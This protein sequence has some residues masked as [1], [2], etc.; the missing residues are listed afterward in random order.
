ML[1]DNVPL[2]VGTSVLPFSLFSTL[3]DWLGSTL[4]SKW[5]ISTATVLV[6]LQ[7][8]GLENS[9]TTDRVSDVQDEN[10]SQQLHNNNLNAE[11]GNSKVYFNILFVVF[12]IIIMWLYIWLLLILLIPLAFWVSKKLLLH[13][14]TTTLIEDLCQ[15][16]FAKTLADVRT[17]VSNYIQAHKDAVFPEPLPRIASV[18]RKGDK[19]IQVNLLSSLPT[20]TTILI[21]L[22]IFSSAIFMTVFL[23]VKIQQESFL[24][25]HITSN[26]INETFSQN[27]EY[28]K[29]LPG[30]ETM[31]K[32][33]DTFVD[34]VYLQGRDWIS[35]KI[36][37]TIGQTAN[38]TKVE[39]QVLQIW[40]QLYHGLFMKKGHSTPKLSRKNSFRSVSDSG[41]ISGVIDLFNMSEVITWLQDNVSA[42]MSL[43]ETLLSVIQSNMTLIMS[44]FT[45]V[46]TTLL[47][48][49]TMVLNFILSLVIFFT[50]LFYLLASSSEQY[51]P[52]EII[53]SVIRPLSM[54][55]PIEKAL[56]EVVSG[57]FGASLKMFGFYGLYTWVN[58]SMFGSNLV[59]IP[60]VLA[61][62]FG[63]VPLITT[64]W[65]CLPSA[66]E[67]WL[68]QGS[69]M[70]AAGLV[71]CQFL[72]TF[73]V[74]TAIYKDIAQ[75][76]GGTHP[77][78]TGLA[79]AGGVYTF[80]LEGAIAGPLI[81]CLVLVA[82]N[83][84][85]TATLTSSNIRQLF[86]K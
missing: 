43:G 86:K 41:L 31:Q 9:D 21:I 71:V 10:Y 81:L 70:R 44:L 32:K 19:S 58:H 16:F 5:R 68:L 80:G 75:S 15:R 24:V 54:G 60:S 74:D 38:V 47:S 35:Q 78:L 49:G 57:V 77:Y 83:L 12:A 62:L 67:I 50:A 1:E 69:I 2:I 85:T 42:L 28:Q 33:M 64:Y 3:S 65:V 53:G 34:T 56:E 82:F 23:T 11:N 27:P 13:N 46:F 22:F 52:V 84:Y 7:S 55:T 18:L 61:A 51:K 37:T 73:V 66:L 30:D 36:G 39:K 63:V 8:K 72:P 20:V 79:V 45:A 6:G 14:S 4:M 59:Y 25:V 26:M 17:E 48:G 29:W 76:G 40:D